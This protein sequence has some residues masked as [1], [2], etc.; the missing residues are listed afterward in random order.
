MARPVEDEHDLA[1][2]LAEDLIRELDVAARDVLRS[3][4]SHRAILPPILL[5]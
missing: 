5:P 1:L 4:C 2:A 3:R